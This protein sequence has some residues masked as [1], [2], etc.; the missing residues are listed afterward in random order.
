MN[1][2]SIIRIS[3]K[4]VLTLAAVCAALVIVGVGLD[5]LML[6]AVF[7]IVSLAALYTSD[8]LYKNKRWSNADKTA[9]SYDKQYDKIA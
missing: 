6:T 8:L 5:N 9:K 3:V 2:N 1:K 7:A 4:A